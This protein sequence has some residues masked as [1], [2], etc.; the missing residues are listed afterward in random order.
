MIMVVGATGQLGT[1]VVRKLVRQG[2]PVRAL[3]RQTSQYQ[4]LQT[5]GVELAFGDLRDPASIDGACQDVD[6]VIAT[7]N[8]A[9]PTQKGDTFKAVDEAGYRH[10]IDSCKK[11]GV[12][13]FI[14]TS[15]PAGEKAN[16]GGLHLAKR[17]TEAYLQQ[18]GLK[19][20]IFRPAPFM[21]VQFAFLGSDIPTRG[22]EAASVLRPFKFSTNFF[23][24]VRNNISTKGTVGIVG[25]GQTRHSYICVDNVADFLVN[26]V[27][28]PQA[29]NAVIDIGGPEALTP[30]EIKAIYEEVLGKPLN[31]RHLPAPVFR[32]AGMLLQPF[33]PAVANILTLNY[34]GA[35]ASTMY[36][37]TRTAPL[38][39]VQLTSAEDFLRQKAS[40]PA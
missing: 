19:Y 5:D 27:D 17:K 13:Q 4:H 28:H 10:L 6:V 3:V 24:S 20:T 18:S 31:A 23:N 39:N 26:A 9:M 14:Y 40:L 8:G 2:M 33:A 1:V 15:V 32:V 38:F 22:A 12:R 7:A 36:D 35:T 16:L 34:V 30:L 37:M 11:H 25:K 21:D 29:Q